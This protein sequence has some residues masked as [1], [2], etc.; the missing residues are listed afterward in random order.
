MISEAASQV[1]I[2]YKSQP[3]W[4]LAQI[5]IISSCGRSQKCCGEVQRPKNKFLKLYKTDFV[6]GI[7][8][9]CITMTWCKKAQLIVQKL[10]S[11]LSC[12]MINTI[13]REQPL[14]DKNPIGGILTIVIIF[15]CHWI[16]VWNFRS[17]YI[18]VLVM[19]W[20]V[21]GLVSLKF[22]L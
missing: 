21:E 15:R 17:N 9:L 8:F 11:S 4:D 10:T 14:L 16:W 2:E 18:D 1:L 3:T 20:V 12:F 19:E 13:S 22:F 7:K 6:P 5:K